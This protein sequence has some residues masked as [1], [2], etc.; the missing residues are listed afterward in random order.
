MFPLTLLVCCILRISVCQNEVEEDYD[1]L[2]RASAVFTSNIY[3]ELTKNTSNFVFSPL[4][5]SMAL[6][7]LSVGANGQTAQ[8]MNT[9]LGFQFAQ[10]SEQE[11]L[12]GSRFLVNNITGSRDGYEFS[13]ANAQFLHQSFPIYSNY[14]R[15]L[16]EDFHA[17]SN[18]ADFSN[19][20]QTL[21]AIN[22]W[23]SNATRG[24]ITTILNR[25]DP[26]D[27]MVLLNAVYFKGTWKK[28]FDRSLTTSD[29]F[30]KEDGTRKQVQMMSETILCKFQRE[31]HLGGPVVELLYKDGTFSMILLLPRRSQNF[32]EFESLITP[33]TLFTI[34]DSL[35]ETNVTVRIPKIKVESKFDLIPKLRVLGI[36]EV[37]TESADLSRISSAHLKVSQVSHKAVI[38]LSEEGVEAAAATAIVTT[39]RSGG[40]QPYFLANRPFMFILRHNPTNTICFMGKVIDV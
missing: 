7:M 35:Q 8:Q 33:A 4:S 16:V 29:A 15:I 31:H 36:N 23:V 26:L 10:L 30:Y 19:S 13:I 18:L 39:T 22:G 5:I 6:S 27:V 37:F 12:L 21:D 17:E 25:I 38:E 14:S 9:T 34:T 3:K 32:T 2:S 11:L 24:K 28:Q 40:F 1:K 20:R